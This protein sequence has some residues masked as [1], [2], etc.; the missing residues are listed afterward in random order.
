M[1]ECLQRE[2]VYGFRKEED[3]NQR[4]VCTALSV[5]LKGSRIN[6][7]GRSRSYVTGRPSG[8]NIHLN[9]VPRMTAACDYDSLKYE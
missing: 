4:V 3:K 2:E 9:A 7:G 6:A 5:V 8:T 1:S